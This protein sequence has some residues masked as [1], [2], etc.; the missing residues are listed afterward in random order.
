[1]IDALQNLGKASGFGKSL[2]LFTTKEELRAGDLLASG[3]SD[4]NGRAVEL[5]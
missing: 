4:G 2:F 1:M 3:W 5:I